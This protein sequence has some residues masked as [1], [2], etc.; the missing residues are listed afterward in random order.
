M[1]ANV[2]QIVGYK[3]TGKTTLI[4]QLIQ[5]LSEKGYRVGTI[6]HDAH[7]FDMDFKGKDT[8]QHR[9]AG[10]H[11]VAITSDQRTVYIEE[12]PVSLEQ[13]IARM[14]DMDIVLVEGFKNEDYPKIVMIKSKEDMELLGRLHN[15]AAIA[16]WSLDMAVNI[17]KPVFRVDDVETIR[18]WLLNSVIGEEK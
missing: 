3:N 5:L 1:S 17:S 8:W 7:S 9:E 6:K 12:K 16:V 15:I 10:A 18:D 13:I 2:Y 4:C 11:S 14:N